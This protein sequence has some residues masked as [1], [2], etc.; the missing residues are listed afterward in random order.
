MTEISGYVLEPVRVGQANGTFTQMPDNYISDQAA[1]SA[2][3]PFDET[4]PRTDYLV[5]V[6]AEGVVN[7][8]PQAR[9]GLLEFARFGYTKNEVIDRFAYDAQAGAFK[10]LRGAAPIEVGVLSVDANEKRLRVRPPV[11][12]D[13][14]AA[15]YRLSVAGANQEW[16][17][18]LVPKDENFGSPAAGTVE[19]SLETGN[20]NWNHPG[21]GGDLRAFAGRRVRFQ[22]QQFFLPKDSTGR[23][24]TVPSSILEPALMLNPLPGKNQGQVPLL[25]FGYG[26]YLDAVEVAAFTETTPGTVQW[27]NTTGELRFDAED[28]STNAGAPVYYDGVLF[29]A[30]LSLPSQDLGAITA[31][32]QPLAHP[33]EI[34]GLPPIGVDLIFSVEG[35]TPYYRFPSVTYRAAATFNAGKKGEVQVD[36]TTG[37]VCFS[38]ADRTRYLGKTVKLYCGN[39]LIE[40]GISVCFLRN[41]VNL[42][43]ALAIK[44][45]AEI[46]SVKGATWADPI[47]ASP[48]IT[49]PSLPVQDPLYPMRVQVIQGQGT[50]VSDAF[51]DLDAPSPA[52][53]LGYYV[54]FDSGTM[55][56]AKRTQAEKVLSTATSDV[57]L[58]DPLLLSS[59]LTLELQKTPE[60]SEYEPL[61]IGVDALV[62]T[63]SGV[64]SL[65]SS[66]RSIGTGTA[67][68]TPPDVLSDPLANFIADGVQPGH[69]VVLSGEKVH[70]IAAVS[71]GTTLRVEPELEAA[72]S[73]AYTIYENREVL[74]DR[75]F[76]EVVL[77]DPSTKVE[78]IRLLGD[79][80]EEL[81]VPVAHVKTSGFRL[82]AAQ[83]SAF[84]SVSLVADDD[85]LTP[86][87]TGTVRVSEESG[88]LMFAPEDLG[89]PVYWSR[90]LIPKIDYQL[91]PQLGLVQFNERL[92]AGEEAR[93][94]YT[95]APPST[96]PPTEPSPP[97]TEYAR[98][99]VRKELTQEHPE[100]TTS[101][102]FNKVGL[103]VAADPAPAVFRGGRPQKLGT[104]CVVD[105]AQS[106]I[107]FL[108]DNHL[109]DALPHGA[110]VGPNERV[111]IDYYVTQAVGGEKT[112]TVLQPPLLTAIVT[113]DETTGEGKPNNRF[114]VHGDQTARF[115]AG[116][117]M[118]IETEQLYL[119]GGASFD[120]AANKTTISLYDSGALQPESPSQ[121]FQDSFHDPK[122]YVSSGPTPFAAAALVPSYFAEEQG[123]YETVA[124]GSNTFFLAGDQTAAYRTGT[125][126]L[127]TDSVGTFTDSLQVTGAAHDAETARTKVMLAAN[128]I[129]QYVQ[130]NQLLLRSVRPI[131]EPPLIEVRTTRVPKLTQPYLVYRKVSDAAGEVVPP[132][133]YTIDET[134]RI[135]FASPLR[136][137]E[138]FSILYT[139]LEQPSANLILRASYTSQI[140]PSAANGL[141]GQT[142]VADYYIRAPDSFYFR[143]EPM[144]NFRGEY[145]AEIAASV[146]SGSSGPQTSNMSQ[147]RLWEQG[148]KSLYFDERHLANQDIIARSSLLFYNDLINLFERYRCA[149][150]GTVVGNND[151]MLLFDG[152]LGRTPATMDLVRNQID[153]TVK[154]SDS[155]YTFTY[156]HGGNP[157]YG[158]N[159]IGTHKKYYLP[160]PLSRFY[161]TARNFFGVSR[162]ATEAGA[163]VL[164]TGSK[165][166]TQVSNLH[167]RQAWGVVTESTKYSGKDGSG[168]DI[169]KLDYAS[170]SEPGFSDQVTLY[171]RTPFVPGMK[172]QVVPRDDQDPFGPVVI[173][174]VANFQITLT[175]SLG[176]G[177]IPAGSTIYQLQTDNS[178]SMITHVA[179]RDF[180]FNGETGQV[181]YIPQ[182]SDEPPNYPVV[183]G[184]AY[185]G[186]L[187]FANSATEPFKFPALFGGAT[188]DDGELTF[189]ILTPDP[190]NE[191]N[192]YLAAE[193][194]LIKAGDGLLRTLTTAPRVST[195]TAISVRTITD[196]TIGA[197][198]PAPQPGDLVRIK[199]GVNGT[200]TAPFRR[201]A[202]VS[203]GSLTVD[204]DA[205]AYTTAGSTSYELVG[206][207]IV[208]GV[209][210]GGSVS[211]LTQTGATFLATVK[212]G[213][214]LLIPSGQRV[215][216]RQITGVLNNTV[217][218]F[219]PNMPSAVTN[220]TSYR[221]DNSLP[222]HSNYTQAWD[223][224]LAGEQSL[225]ATEQQDLDLLIAKAAAGE[226]FF[227]LSADIGAKLTAWRQEIPS[228]VA[229]LAPL[230]AK[231]ASA[232]VDGF[233]AAYTYALT[234]MKEDLD[235]RAQQVNARLDSIATIISDIQEILGGTDR[236]YDKRYIWIDT[237]INLENGLLVRQET[238][239]RNRLKAQAEALKQLTKL[240]A[241]GGV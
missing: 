141:L 71:S 237:R 67:I 87:P 11:Q 170:G 74:A 1:F 29:A 211:Q 91:Q 82:S 238:A 92:L 112:F 131:F 219:T 86:P 4:A 106:L 145:A 118:R 100:P 114:V 203:S 136:R 159:S 227:G 110:T 207:T 127:F 161:P 53:G 201:V 93:I 3:Y 212:I 234:L 151:G 58:P 97:V 204:P 163:D 160:G 167:R 72:G 76:D 6:M 56:F 116:H 231:L 146:S 190:S 205:S 235:A 184:R 22:Q 126:V 165:N 17:I 108:P 24:G 220:G 155:P 14:A 188:D 173:Q 28:V 10:P 57:G 85:A 7:P 19:L 123:S 47:I 94:T 35:V 175:T 154:V 180:S 209:A 192:G 214:T 174:R 171:A 198:S 103:T 183:G 176:A 102:S 210:T 149:L 98:F 81:A 109:T 135:V 80:S 23:L 50:Y 15:P 179:G 142:L 206:N 25:R 90:T 187:T 216:R 137:N 2:A 117:L 134:G 121:V 196:A 240:L 157:P 37:Q 5:M 226:S 48:Q 32:A 49:L 120:P 140:A 52:D 132:S 12:G 34:V 162:S 152:V 99:L 193:A 84:A 215:Y 147:P 166:V 129:R 75:Y 169:V 31:P 26:F 115:P 239:V 144:E 223:A 107:T 8:G 153:D 130:G 202:Q 224:A 133:E 40:R 172:C 51:R 79:A 208:S 64:V 83:P 95:V 54:D 73:F 65:T 221:V 158:V 18:A 104:Q 199:S 156:T 124:R 44:D 21:T 228:L 45:V 13:V 241:V 105:T 119:L 178:G 177:V 111:Y 125:V 59:N 233:D 68:A 113:I 9:Y 128:A 139:G 218:T 89:T 62:D 229:P 168:Y 41:P 88:K 122:I 138:E 96:I 213:Y 30:G 55:V 189:P 69:L 232:P 36:P 70:S 197:M 181:T 148:R 43:G 230:R 66:N 60:S 46:Y 186:S 78:R 236:L 39:L 38:A 185:S 61:R 27:L 33:E 225:Y 191:K 143:V 182:S 77:L 164:D 217:L 222:T 16:S 42:D 200:A 20:L 63:T 194:A 101:L 195:A 150:D